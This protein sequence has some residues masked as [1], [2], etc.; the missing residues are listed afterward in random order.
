MSRRI[1]LS[2]RE[3][4]RMAGMSSLAAGVYS[5]P[6][7]GSVVAQDPNEVSIMFW[8]GPPLIGIRE[9]ALAPF[10][11]AYPDCKLNFISVPGGGYNDKLLTM[12]AANEAPDVF[13]IR[14]GQL[15]EFLSKDLLVDL[16]PY[17]DADDYD[18]S[19]FPDLAIEAYSHEG[20]IYGVPDN[21]ATIALFYNQD[22]FEEAGAMP[23]TAQWDDEGWTVN[24]F[25]SSCEKLTK[26][27]GNR[28][29][30]YAYDVSSWD[31]IW[32]IWVRIFGGQV[33]DD[34]F[35]PTE[36]VLNEAPAVEALQFYADLRWEHGFA[37][38]PDAMAE[39]GTDTLMQTG[40]L[41]MFQSGSW[42]FPNYRNVDFNVALGHFP[43]GKG[44][45]AN[46]VFYYPLV[47]PKTTEVPECAWNLLKFFNGPAMETIIKEG[48]LQGTTFEAQEKW[49]VTDPL[50]PANKQVMVDA[51]RHFVAP[52]PVLTNWGEI[53]N[54]MQSELD[55]LFIGEERDAKVVM[56][57]IVEQV[58]PMIIE[59]QWRS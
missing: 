8:D 28:T 35:F 50:P 2:R 19:Q 24:D 43:T 6:G 49:F 45:R 47:V 53:T 41:A 14:I 25:F 51:A 56:D 42:S 22:M 10:D 3:F 29:T 40:R 32:Q 18:L 7:V 33:V 58:N 54:I 13:I 5:I 52:D 21:V 27:D 39:F 31:L 9:K 16:K 4:L 59:G 36:C 11:E 1:N 34:P 57:K 37:P 48:G 46:Y 44:G 20:G 15:P 23:P 38:R 30:Q 17:I 55:L 12:L 26:R